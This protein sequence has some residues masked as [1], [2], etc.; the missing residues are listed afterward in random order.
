MS[1][2]SWLHLLL[3]PS[4]HPCCRH[5]SS[6]VGFGDLP[7]G[8]A[9]MVLLWS[10]SPH[11][12]WC[13]K[14]KILQNFVLGKKDHSFKQKTTKLNVLGKRYDIPRR[15][16][17]CIVGCDWLI[18]IKIAVSTIS[19]SNN[20]FR[21]LW[22]CNAVLSNDL[23]RGWS[24]FSS[25]VYLALWER[26][27]GL[28]AAQSLVNLPLNALSV[29]VESGSIPF[30]EPHNCQYYCVMQYSTY[31]C[32]ENCGPTTGRVTICYLVSS[33]LGAAGTEEPWLRS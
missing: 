6:H 21:V 13:G 31:Q 28:A 22:F 11:Q 25:E 2:E 10:A 27:R 23:S 3:I 12:L 26:Y 33:R 8:A 4:K 19:A 14:M 20:H 29:Y 15:F 7:E 9:K 17:S 18:T 30:T 16:S 32:C 1:H 24:N 5:S